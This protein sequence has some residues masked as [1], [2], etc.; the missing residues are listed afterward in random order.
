MSEGF[1]DEDDVLLQ[2]LENQEEVISQQNETIESLA[3]EVEYLNGLLDNRPGKLLKKGKSFVVVAIDEPY[4][5][6]VY[7]LIKHHELLKGRWTDE[8]EHLMTQ[9]LIVWDRLQVA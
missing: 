8:D 4:F 7:E 3:Q 1:A 2:K 9:M 5:K 6:Q